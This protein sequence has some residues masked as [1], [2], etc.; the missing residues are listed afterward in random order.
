[1][2]KNTSSGAVAS[3]VNYLNVRLEYLEHNRD[4]IGARIYLTS[5]AVTQ[6]REIRIENNYVSQ[7]PPEAHFGVGAATR[8]DELRVVWPRERDAPR[9]ETRLWD[10]AVNQQLT[11]HFE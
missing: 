5:S 9:A 10:V 8:I 7:G 6:M 3:D 4:A 11:V 2:A 1:M